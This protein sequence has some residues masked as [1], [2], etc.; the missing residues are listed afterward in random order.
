MEQAK[1]LAVLAPMMAVLQRLLYVQSGDIANVLH[2]NLEIQS[3]V[4]DSMIMVKLVLEVEGEQLE[5]EKEQL[6]IE[7]VEQ[8]KELAVLDQMMGVLQKL[9]YV[10]S[11]DIASVL[12]TNQEILNV[13]QVLMKIPRKR[14]PQLQVE[15]VEQVMEVVVLDLMMGV[16]QRLLYALNGDIVSVLHTNLE[17]QSVALASIQ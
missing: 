5:E 6:G 8:V 1:E 2:T 12:H 17:I 4:L 15:S 7:S 10:L 11:G 9:L 16:L 14:E 3:V 13:V